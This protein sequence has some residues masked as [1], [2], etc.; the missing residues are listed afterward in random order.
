MFGGD[1]KLSIHR[2]TPY[3][4][5]EEDKRYINIFRSPRNVVGSWLKFT[6]QD[7]TPINYI[8]AIPDLIKEMSSYSGW[9]GDKS[10]DVL[11]VKFEELLTA[12][13]TLKNVAKF[14]GKTRKHNH[15]KNIWGGTPT[16]T[17]SPFIW[18]DHWTPAIE[19]TWVINGGEVLENTWGY[20]PH[21]IWLRKKQ[22]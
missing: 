18:R 8:Q 6:K 5:K 9:L 16:F 22:I 10:K 19:Y 11:N 15:F 1:S 20:D 3:D 14:I 13:K 4:H 7:I 21:K 12:K 17:G 2:H